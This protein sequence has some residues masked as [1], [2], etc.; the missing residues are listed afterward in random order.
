MAM[1]LGATNPFLIEA[2]N[3]VKY[4]AKFPGNPEGKKVL[5]NE[6]ICAELALLLKLP[7]PKY[8]LI[9]ITNI[10]YYMDKLDNISNINGT[11]FCSQYIETANPVPS[12]SILRTVDNSFDVVKTIFFDIIIGNNDR[13]PGNVLIDSK[14]N[15]FIIIDH[16]HVFIN[17][18]I[19]DT[20]SLTR[21]I[22]EKID[23]S[24]LNPI[25]TNILI[26]A[27]NEKNHRLELNEYVRFLK[28]ISSKE[29]ENI[30]KKVPKD[31][32]LDEDEGVLL[33]QFIVDRL[34]RIDEIC[35][36]LKVSGDD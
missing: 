36:I 4:V 24:E 22:E 12:Y 1:K 6:F 32:E 25:I 30:V 10:D 26:Q 19:W 28:S 3:D 35:S 5:I 33:I 20:Y 17:G 8:E 16:S 13:N 2:S 31:W 11:V 9:E 27:L 34:S 18:A 23:I 21:A 14:T 29:I 7:I 15:S